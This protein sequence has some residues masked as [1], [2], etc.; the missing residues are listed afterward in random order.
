MLKRRCVSEAP[1][2][3]SS[4]RGGET[5]SEGSS[6]CSAARTEPAMLNGSPAVRIIKFCARDG[7][8]V[9]GA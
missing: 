9:Y 2:T 7:V 6:D 5:G 8:D 4:V 3:S 1:T